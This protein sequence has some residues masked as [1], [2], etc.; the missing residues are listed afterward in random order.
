MSKLCERETWA[1]DSWSVR[2]PRWETM[3]AP[4]PP[5]T[6]ARSRERGVTLL[7]ALVVV[8]IIGLGLAVTV[9]GLQRAR[10]RAVMLGE[11]NTV[12]EAI[13]ISR[14]TA[15]RSGRQVVLRVPPGTETILSAVIDTDGDDVFETTDEVF[16]RWPLSQRVQVTN[17]ATFPLRPV[18][19]GSDT[20]PGVQVRRDGIVLAN[21][22]NDGTGFGW[23]VFS[24]L[25]GNQ[26]R[27][28][29]NSGTGTVIKEMKIPSTTTWTTDLRHWR[30]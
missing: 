28:Q 10:V 19:V 4:A 16:K 29:I 1:L 17:D 24:D 9:P 26:V 13:A 5:S 18:T 6:C 23:V 11:V 21:V 7:E 2:S 27:L 15:I 20:G 14:V 25:S 3:A 8:A 22:A 30:F 12:A